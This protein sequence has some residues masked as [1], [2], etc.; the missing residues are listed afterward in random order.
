MTLN[1]LELIASA[2]DGRKVSRDDLYRFA[3]SIGSG[4]VPD[5]QV[6]AW[7]M[8]V[9][10][11]GLS[12]EETMAFAHAVRDSGTVMRWGEGPPLADK[13]S[14]GGV[15]DKISLVLAPLAAACG[16]R[17]PMVSGRSLGHTG[18]TL[19]KLES[20]PGFDVRLSVEKFMGQVDEIGVSMIGQTSD[21]APADRKLYALRDATATVESIPLI[22]ASIMGKKLAENTDAIVFDVK[23]GRGAFMKTRGEALELARS[24]T[25]VAG[26]SGVESRALVTS[27][28]RPLGKTVGNALEVRESLEVLR[29]GGPGDVRELAVLLTAYMLV[30]ADPESHPVP[31]GA[32]AFCR[33]KL[34]DGSA[35]ERFV[36]MVKYQGG[37]LE[38]FGKLPHAPVV[39][40]VKAPRSG[41]FC[42]LDAYVAGET[43]R[44]M[45][46]G[47]YTM[48]D[49]IDPL[50]GWERLARRDEEVTH[51][52]VVGLVH[53]GSDEDARMAADRFSS[54]LLWDMPVPPLVMEVV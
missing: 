10:L 11:N 17:V 25:R 30:C 46:G 14:T 13:H 51:G 44:A 32:V 33:E 23:A 27:M 22:T 54:S 37:D 50:V 6:A 18:G 43:V 49:D 9:Y 7:L 19:D 39:A 45:G 40:S 48:E 31:D 35:M 3:S 21:L 36:R 34:D 15:G 12:A 28:D 20:I 41:V 4:G 5:Y 47:R 1:V 24:L 26:D 2:R 52:T 53:A 16:L 8:A 42:G 38:A 29:G